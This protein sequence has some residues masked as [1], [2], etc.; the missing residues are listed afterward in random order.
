[1]CM[2]RRLPYVSHCNSWDG[3]FTKF[4]FQ[5][6]ILLER[7]VA[8]SQLDRICSLKARTSNYWLYNIIEV[9][10]FVDKPRN[11][12]LVQHIDNPQSTARMTKGSYDRLAE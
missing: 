6:A 11:A 5:F 8:V 7:I 9:A 4:R 3:Q 1:M 2:K 10:L 12:G